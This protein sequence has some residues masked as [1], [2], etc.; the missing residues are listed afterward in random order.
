VAGLLDRRPRRHHEQQR[1]PFDAP[2][3]EAEELQR[4]LIRPLEVVDRE[5]ERAVARQRGRQ[6]EE[7]VD[8]GV[9]VRLG[10]VGRHLLTAQ[11]RPRQ[12]RGAREQL[13]ALRIRELEHHGIQ[14]L[15]S[16]AERDVFLELGAAGAEDACVIHSDGVARRAQK[17]C[18]ADSRRPLD[19]DE[20]AVALQ[21]IARRGSQRRKLCIPLDERVQC[22]FGH[23]LDS[24]PE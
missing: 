15:A 8:R 16:N 18:L 4:G 19:D 1:E 12:P 2:R 23:R 11:H 21:G 9:A 3:Q 20:T 6:P 10:G 14:E 22:R 24:K 13:V 5:H 17:P 7:A